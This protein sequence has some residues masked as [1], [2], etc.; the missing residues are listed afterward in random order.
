M[1]F[2]LSRAWNEEK[3]LSPHEKSNVRP[4]LRCSTFF[5]FYRA[6]NLPSLFFYHDKHDAIDIAD[7]SC[8]MQDACYMNFEIQFNVESLWLSGRASQRGIGRSEL[9]FL[10]GTHSLV[11]RRKTIFLS[12]WILKSVEIFDCWMS[13]LA[14][15]VGKK[16]IQPNS[17]AI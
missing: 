16:V 12:F 6:Q 4:S 7:P 17:S 14:A 11:T 13:C 3:I 1:F 2:V 9:R 5:I 15:N 10:M 8:S